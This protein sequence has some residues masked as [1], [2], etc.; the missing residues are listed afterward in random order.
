MEARLAELASKIQPH[1]LFNTLNTIQSLIRTDP[2]KARFVL[3]KLA[4]ILQSLF[5]SP[6]PYRTLAAEIEFVKAYLAIQEIRFGPVRLGV[7]MN[8]DPA[9]NEVI[10]PAMIIQPIVENSIKH[11][12][13]RQMAPGRIE[14]S[15]KIEGDFLSLCV[16]DNGQGMPLEIQR[17]VKT[18]GHGLAN[19]AGRLQLIYGERYLFTIESEPKQGTA[20]TFK[21]P[22]I[23]PTG[24]EVSP[25]GASDD[26]PQSR[27]SR[28]KRPDR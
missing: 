14:I 4:S 22:L 8:I 13:S 15:G 11:G 28:F 1:F 3:Q 2:D 7:A 16:K 24:S 25:E 27:G 9:I 10:I 12:L 17:R 23:C 21:L 19:V 18:I 26:P 6:E 5:D 20:V